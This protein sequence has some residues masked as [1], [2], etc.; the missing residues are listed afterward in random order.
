MDKRH[1]F[2]THLALLLVFALVPLWLRWEFAPPPFSSVY[3][4]GFV[5]ASA[6]LL[7]VTLWMLGGFPG[8][9]TFIR[10]RW[11]VTWIL[12]LLLLAGW[13][14]ISAGWAFGRDMGYAGLAPNA[15]LQLLIVAL[16]AL[17]TACVAPQPRR[18]LSVLIASMLLHGAIGGLQVAQQAS[19]GLE[20]LG[21]FSLHPEESGVS[22]IQSDDLRWLRPYGLLPHPNLLGGV[23][24]IGLLASA[25]WIVDG[26]GWRYGGALLAFLFGFYL[27]L[28]TFSR[29]AWLG[30]ATGVLF[31][32]PFVLRKTNFWRRIAPVLVGSAI[33]GAIFVALYNPLLL[34]RVGVGN[35]NTEMRSIADRIVY[36]DVAHRAIAQSPITG[37]GAGNFPW[38]A[39]VYIFY[40]TDYDLRGDN[41]HN[42]YLGV[43]ADLGIVGLGL[44][45]MSLISGTI[46]ALEQR[47][48]ARIALLAGVIA[49]AV[50]GLFDHY[51]WTLPLTQTLWIG[52]LAVALARPAGSESAA[53]VESATT[54]ERP[55]NPHL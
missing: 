28:L 22:V 43:W 3:V 13:A 30:F 2:V 47:D 38:Y 18:V 25:N 31:A 27:L 26:R 44:L 34:S 46:A 16:F 6:M 7:T 14:A 5:I 52:L 23:I 51:P 11:R 55:H 49:F 1:A 50:I 8:W 24:V 54:A 32:L 42:I 40:N 53:A 15:A 21:E 4:L 19:L 36:T 20:V 48:T 10:H 29:G 33:L 37:I 17:A 35:E 41:V 39:S 9:R 45:L 12:T